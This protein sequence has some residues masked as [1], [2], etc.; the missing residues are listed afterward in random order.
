MH[1]ILL[2]LASLLLGCAAPQAAPAPE[3]APVRLVSYNIRAGTDLS[4]EPNLERVAALMDSLGADVVLLQEVDRGTRRSGGVDQLEV[5]A[6]ATGMEGVFG[7]AIDF[8]GG[9]FGNAILS[10]WPLRSVRAVPLEVEVP[11][12]LVDR[13]Y[14]P[15]SLLHAVAETPAGALHVLNTHLD[16]QP[17]P[18]FRHPQLVHLLAYLAEEVPEGARVVLGG[19]LNAPPDAVEIRA[20][21]L[22]LEDAW[23][24]CGEGPG[25]TFPSDRPLRRID[26]LHLRGLRCTDARV[27][28]TTV[29]DHR[30]VTVDVRETEG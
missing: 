27:L 1:R 25:Y 2:P 23:S 4:G 21:K 30:P 28:E 9:E 13:Y 10:R 5:L 12:E 14:E 8:D 24:E 18:V 15:R 17:D 3:S 29:S 22:H 7:K 16:H 19:D 20:L 6:R 11:D 26:Y